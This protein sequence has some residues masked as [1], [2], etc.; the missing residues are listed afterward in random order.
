MGALTAQAVN[1]PVF[2]PKSAVAAAVAAAA[3]ATTAASTE[4]TPSPRLP[5]P[6]HT[7]ESVSSVDS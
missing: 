2:I 5:P 6:L 3:V 4:A 1:A 7:T